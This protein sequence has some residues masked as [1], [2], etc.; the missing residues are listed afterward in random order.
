[1][2]NTHPRLKLGKAA[3]KKDSRNFLFAALLRKS[4]KV[5]AEYDFD[6]EYPELIPNPMFANDEYGD[7]VIAGRA[8]QT[9]RFELRET[10]RIPRITDK[11][12]VAEYLKETGGDD[13]GL[14]VLD[15]L[16]L[17]RQRGWKAGGQTL[18]IKA[19]SEISLTA[20]QHI[21]Q[22]IYLDVGVGL[23]LD[24]PWSAS[25]QFNAG[26]AWD[27]VKGRDGKPGSWGGHYVFVSGYTKDGPTCVT[28]G[29][30]QQMT[31]RFI[32][33]Y[34]DECYAIIDAVDKTRIRLALD[35]PKLEAMLRAA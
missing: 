31:W 4:I 19:F 13:D 10:S 29:T 5:P 27:V 17:W 30:K 8:H 20:T 6:K 21:K 3:A 1:M 22:A 23:G 24:L 33:K 18:K 16:K 25:D 28:W 32:Q 35:V 14:I 26:K 15:S 7:C 34:A 11:Q 12:V 2:A 9:R